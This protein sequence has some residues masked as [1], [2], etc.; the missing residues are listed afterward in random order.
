METAAATESAV[1]LSPDDVTEVRLADVASGVFLTGTLE[2]SQTVSVRS[3]TAGILQQLT[4]DKGASVQ[5]G[6]RLGVIQAEA[7]ASQVTG[8][9]AGVAA[10]K[11]AIA[12]NEAQLATAKQRVEGARKLHSAGAMSTVDFQSAEAQAQAI[13]GQLAGAQAQLAAAQSQLVAAREAA[14]RTAVDAPISGVVSERKVSQGEAV[15]V[16]TDL[17]TIVSLDVL[18]LA[19]QVPVQQAAMVR[20]GQSVTFTL[21]A[22]PGQT[23]TARVGRV[24]PVADPATRRVGISLELP[25]PGH[26]LVSGQFVTGRVITA[27]VVQGL[28]IPRSA[29]RGDEKARFVL[30]IEGDA[31]VR[32]DLQIGL[33]DDAASSV[34]VMSGLQAGDRVIASPALDIQAGAKVRMAPSAAAAPTG[35][36]AE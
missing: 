12:A 27:N 22:Y 17:L 6:Q 30:L 16:G 9:E 33:F 20:V 19:G 11:S 2:P 26:R 10:A 24:D 32:R 28:M 35:K 15:G 8:A 1:I 23:F 18:L 3:Q 21:D 31:V 7:L 36:G 34:V 25:N 5:R 4:V 29:L 14:G 13:A